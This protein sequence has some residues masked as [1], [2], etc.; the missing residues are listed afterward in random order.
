MAT[1]ADSADACTALIML[2]LYSADGLDQ[3][4]VLWDG[5]FEHERVEALRIQAQISAANRFLNGRQQ[6][7]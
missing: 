6:L 7:R 3:K 1:R 4:M 2:C 5:D